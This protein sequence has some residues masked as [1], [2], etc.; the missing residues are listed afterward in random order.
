MLTIEATINNLL[1]RSTAYDSAIRWIWLWWVNPPR[2]SNR[3]HLAH[4]REEFDAIDRT[5]LAELNAWL[6]AR[7]AI[8]VVLCGS[9]LLCRCTAAAGSGSP[10]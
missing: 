1:R 7:G 4:R 2:S 8:E 5:R 10:V 6:K 3:T 9:H